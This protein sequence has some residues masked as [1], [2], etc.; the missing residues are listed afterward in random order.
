L[1]CATPAEKLGPVGFKFRRL[2]G[3]FW[4]HEMR[5]PDRPILGTAKS[6]SGNKS[7]ATR[8]PLSFYEELVESGMRAVRPMRRKGEL[9][10][11][12]QLQLTGFARRIHQGHAPDFRVVF[13]RDDNFGDRFA[14]PTPTPKL[15]F[16]RR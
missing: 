6:T 16:V 11:T 10:I 7:F 5:S 1:R 8:Q 15:R 12:G 4:N 9:K 2:D 3:G 14:W 13:R